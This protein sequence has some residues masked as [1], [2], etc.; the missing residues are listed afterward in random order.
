MKKKVFNYKPWII[1]AVVV[2]IILWFFGMY[3]GF[4]GASESVDGQWANVETQYQRRV[5]LIPNLVETVKGYADHEEGVFTEIT[6][7]RSQWQTATSNKNVGGQVQAA[8]GLEGALSKLLLVAEKYP[9][10][11]ASANFLALQDELAGTENKIAVER[12]RFNDLTRD[13]NKKIKKIPG[14]WIAGMFGFEEKEY[15]EA[16]EGSEEAPQ[17]EF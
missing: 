3:N 6:K 8:K 5:D 10:L 14:K 15:F 4:V 17:V 16:E 11:K 13:Y 2:V 12:K 7:L 1:V 9:D